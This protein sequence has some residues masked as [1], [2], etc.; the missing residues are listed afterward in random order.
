MSVGSRMKEARERIGL[1]RNEL[2]QIIDV[3]PSAISNYENDI[4][5]PKVEILYSM[6]THLKI[7]ANYI[8]QDEMNDRGFISPTSLRGQR[9]GRLYD[10]ADD[11]AKQIVELTLKPF[12]DGS[13]E[14]Y[15][16]EIA[17]AMTELPTYLQSSAA[18]LGNYQDDDGFDLIG[19]PNVPRRANIAVRVSGDSMEPDYHDGDIVFVETESVLRDGEIGIF[20]YD[21]GGYIKK[22]CLNPARLVSLNPKYADIELNE[23]M[24]FQT[25]GRV[26]GVYREA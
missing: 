25:I 2:A 4:S 8:F 7:D 26:V 15:A 5:H 16:A 10:K 6:L 23:E 21:G 14:E 17:L 20:N 13:N 9:V 3:T 11:H 24:T 12:D 1:S 18:G 22:L 19:F